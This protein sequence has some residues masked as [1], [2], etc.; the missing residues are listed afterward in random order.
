MEELHIFLYYSYMWLALWANRSWSFL[1]I[2]D[3]TLVNGLNFSNLYNLYLTF[4]TELGA[5]GGI[6]LE[7]TLDLPLAKIIPI[8][9]GQINHVLCDSDN[10]YFQDLFKVGS[11]RDFAANIYEAFSFELD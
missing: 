9:N 2:L 5:V 3:W 7:S 6:E 10:N 4:S 8:I 1:I 11:A